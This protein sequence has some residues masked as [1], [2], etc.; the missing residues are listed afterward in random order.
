[1]HRLFAALACFLL[2]VASASAQDSLAWNRSASGK[3]AFTQAGFYRWHD[4]GVSA[5]ALSV[6]V[7]GEAERLGT[8]W[9]QRHEVHLRYGLVKQNDVD[10]RKA[11]DVIHA[12]FAFTNQG[13]ALFGLLEP[14][15]TVDLRSQFASGFNYKKVDDQGVAARISGPLSPAIFI[16]SVGMGYS[17]VAAIETQ[18]GIAAKQ[19]LVTDPDLRSRYKVKADRAIRSELGINLQVMVEFSPFENVRVDHRLQLFAS[20]NQP[21]RPDLLS[22]TM[23]AMTV[24]R[25][26]QVN[27]EYV[28]KL[29]RDVSRSVQMKE[30]V[31]LAVAFSLI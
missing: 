24:N 2:P 25:W 22:E 28:A 13:R 14:T 29:D 16:E 18:L 4:G 20:F 27:L 26:L 8:S 19:T 1:M 5:L 30:V 23:V 12:H 11:E 6:G 7:N 21:D 3:V 31:S 15:L 10:L 17:P 9:H